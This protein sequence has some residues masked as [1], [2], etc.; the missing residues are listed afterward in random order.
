ML[1]TYNDNDTTSGGTVY[2]SFCSNC[3]RSVL[4]T[5]TLLGE[6]LKIANDH[7]SPVYSAKEP[8]PTKLILKGGLFDEAPAPGKVFFDE[9]RPAWLSV[10]KA[11][12]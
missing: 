6:D 12:L 1:K 9:K 11:A 7:P 5:T 10:T 2:R 8:N 4:Q 3:G